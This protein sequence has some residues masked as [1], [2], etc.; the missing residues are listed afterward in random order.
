MGDGVLKLRSKFAH[1]V[2]RTFNLTGFFHHGT[3]CLE[4]SEGLLQQTER[5]VK[6]E[7]AEQVNRHVVARFKGG[8]ERVGTC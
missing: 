5:L 2:F 4:L 3:V 7:H 8:N 1:A 6:A